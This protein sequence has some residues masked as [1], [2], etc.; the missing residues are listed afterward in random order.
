VLAAPLAG[1]WAGAVGDIATDQARVIGREGSCNHELRQV[2]R[3]CGALHITPAAVSPTDSERLI[4]L[5]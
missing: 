1:Q 4:W 3:V 5:K 2:A